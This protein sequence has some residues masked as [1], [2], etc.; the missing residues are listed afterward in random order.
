MKNHVQ[1]IGNIGKAPEQTARTKDGKP[2]V[3]FSLAQDASV[4]DATT[5]KFVRK[6]P[7]WFQISCFGSLAER[8]LTLQKGDLISVSGE[9]KSRS[10]ETST[11]EKRTSVEVVARSLYRIERLR[12]T[13]KS[14]DFDSF[15]GHAYEGG[16]NL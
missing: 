14:G 6:D 16:T 3:C 15:T 4:M 1:L 5:Q 2:V 11:G 12:A 7:Q 13:E 8:V 9:L 10:Y